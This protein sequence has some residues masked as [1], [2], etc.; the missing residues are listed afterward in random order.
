MN[1]KRQD[2][3]LWLRINDIGEK[4]DVKNIF[5]LVYKKIKDKFE[6]NNLTDEQ[7]KK[8]KRHGSEFIEDT[9]FITPINAL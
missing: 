2:K 7:I 9:K 5:D 1:Y 6:T 8:Y 4:L 3:V